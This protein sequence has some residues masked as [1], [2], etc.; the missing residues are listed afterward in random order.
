MEKNAL[1]IAAKTKTRLEW[2][3]DKRLHLTGWAEEEKESE[4]VLLVLCC[5]LLVDCLRLNECVA[6][7]QTRKPDPNW[8]RIFPPFAALLRSCQTK[9]KKQIAHQQETASADS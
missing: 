8:N 3:K 6:T 7:K 4:G 2:E 5:L 1:E 9:E